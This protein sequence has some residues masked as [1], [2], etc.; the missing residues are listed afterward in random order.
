MFSFF[1]THHLREL[2]SANHSTARPAIEQLHWSNS[3]LSALFEVI[4]TLSSKGEKYHVTPGNRAG[5]ILLEA[6]LGFS[7]L[8]G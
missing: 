3:C 5:E 2:A 1:L 4:F 7:T 8:Q 6:P